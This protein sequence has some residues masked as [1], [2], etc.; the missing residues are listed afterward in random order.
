MF[1]GKIT[2]QAM[3]ELYIARPTRSWDDC[4]AALG[5]VCEGRRPAFILRPAWRSHCVLPSSADELKREGGGACG[6]CGSLAAK[7][8]CGYPWLQ[9]SLAVRTPL[10]GCKG[11]TKKEST[12]GRSVTP[13]QS[14][15]ARL[16]LGI[17]GIALRLC[18]YIQGQGAAAGRESADCVRTAKCVALKEQRA[19]SIGGRL[20]PFEFRF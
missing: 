11:Q 3:S 4:R 2:P 18:S 10:F 1:V 13:R 9:S 12:H 8:S 20:G 14:W 16:A 7:Q 6:A 17:D 5:A 15:C 19:P